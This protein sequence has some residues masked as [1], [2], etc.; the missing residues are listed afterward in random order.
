[1]VSVKVLSLPGHLSPKLSKKQKK[2]PHLHPSTPNWMIKNIAVMLIVV[3]TR[4]TS[5]KSVKSEGQ[6]E[7]LTLVI[8]SPSLFSSPR[9]VC[10]CHH[11]QCR[12]TWSRMCLAIV[13][14]HGRLEC[15]CVCVGRELGGGF[16]GLSITHTLTL[17]SLVNNPVSA[18]EPLPPRHTNTPRVAAVGCSPPPPNKKKQNKKNLV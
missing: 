11:G 7:C 12:M 6:K 16:A 15:V 4:A 8:R 5:L 18:V 9:S 2:L 17:S 10:L 1:M 13:F 3:N 14:S